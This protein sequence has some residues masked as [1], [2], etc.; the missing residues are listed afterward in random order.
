M[1]EPRKPRVFDPGDPAIVE[2]PPASAEANADVQAAATPDANQTVR[3]TLADLGQ[4]GLRW[5]T[6]LA[7][8][9]AGAA[10]LGAGA[11]F[12]R[13]VS[14]ALV[15]EDWL[16]W[17]TLVLLLVAAFAALMLAA[18]RADRLL[19]PRPPQ[20]HPGR[21]RQRHRRPRPEARAQ[22]GAAAGR[23]LRPPSRAVLERAPLPRAC[24]RRARCGRAPGARRPRDGG[25]ARLDGTPPHHPLGQARRHRHGAVA[26]GADRRHL[27][28]GR[29]HAPAAR[30]RRPLR[31]PSRLLRRAAGWRSW[32][33]PT[34]S[35]PAASP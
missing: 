11:W 26:H 22:G 4:R 27:C 21:H 15:R 35:P 17:T 3:P 14:A 1:S 12:A 31:R 10:L 23:A 9:L 7:S 20:P 29:E 32:S 8:A 28:G 24:P 30:A 5:G 6:L 13:L 34:S 18:A 19:A 2:E 16:G 25:A 33:S